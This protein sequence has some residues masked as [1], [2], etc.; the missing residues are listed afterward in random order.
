MKNLFIIFSLVLLLSSCKQDVQYY[1]MF[2]SPPPV[3]G[4]TLVFAGTDQVGH[5]N[6]KFEQQRPDV[7]LLPLMIDP[8]YAGHMNSGFCAV[9]SN[10]AVELRK[11]PD[12]YARPLPAKSSIAGFCSESDYNYYLLKLK[13]QH[14]LK[15]INDILND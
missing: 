15:Q 9:V 8:A 2:K 1:A 3:F 12:S 5:S 7:F 10:G 13:G 11:M 14:L 6:G 4:N